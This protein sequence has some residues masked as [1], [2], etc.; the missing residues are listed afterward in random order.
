MSH[1]RLLQPP[2]VAADQARHEDHWTFRVAMSFR[3]VLRL[4]PNWVGSGSRLKKAAP[5]PNTKI[6]KLGS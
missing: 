5:A 6:C 1:W 4:R 2:H 3:P